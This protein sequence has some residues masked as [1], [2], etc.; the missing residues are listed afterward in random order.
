[1]KTK[2]ALTI[3]FISVSIS[4]FV[5]Y[6]HNYVSTLMLSEVVGKTENASINLAVNFFDFDTG[7]TRSDIK[8][9]DNNKDYWISRINELDTIH[10]NEQKQQASIQL[11]SDMMEDPVLNKICSGFL[12]LGSDISLEIIEMIL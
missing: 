9:L 8:H 1:M 6:H 11:L 12:K 5:Y 4:L 10:N 3:I 7:L 2:I